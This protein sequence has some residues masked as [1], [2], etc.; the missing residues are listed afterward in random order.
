MELEPAMSGAQRTVGD[1][2]V[3][4]NDDQ[5]IRA[6]SSDT[7]ALRSTGTRTWGDQARIVVHWMPTNDL[8]SSDIAVYY[9]V[10]LGVR[11]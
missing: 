2:A 5:T 9:P 8:L 11:L 3:L 7:D 6:L 10:W 1:V 4:L